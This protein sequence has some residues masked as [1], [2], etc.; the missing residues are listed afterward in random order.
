MFFIFPHQDDILV[1]QAEPNE[2]DNENENTPTS[3]TTDNIAFTNKDIKTENNKA[4]TPI[5]ARNIIFI[6]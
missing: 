4:A 1:E 5:Q 6:F 3:D 2:N